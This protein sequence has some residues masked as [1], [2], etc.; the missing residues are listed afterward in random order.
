MNEK[1]Y[2]IQLICKNFS[3]SFVVS[4]LHKLQ[5]KERLISSLKLKHSDIDQITINVLL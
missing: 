4:A 1:Y 5:A 2:K 3:K